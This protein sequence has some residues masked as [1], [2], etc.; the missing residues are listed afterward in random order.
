M[1]SSS[2]G[3]GWMVRD[4]IARAK[5]P[6]S[7][8]VPAGSKGN[9]APFDEEMPCYFR[10]AVNRFIEL[11][12]LSSVLQKASKSDTCSYQAARGI[13]VTSKNKGNNMNAM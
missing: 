8:A 10:L 11:S 7:F 4:E 12:G 13:R 9:D 1:S 2:A 5:V 6:D 3:V